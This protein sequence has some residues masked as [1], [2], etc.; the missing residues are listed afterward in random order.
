MARS[1]ARSSSAPA[2][3]VIMP[4]SN[5]ATTSRPSTGSNP[6]KSGIHSVGIGALRDSAKNGC[7]TTVF[8][9][10]PPRC[11]QFGEKSALSPAWERLREL[12]GTEPRSQ[13]VPAMWKFK[14]I[15]AM[16]IESAE[17]ISAEEA[18]RRVL[19][20]ENPGLPGKSR[21]TQTLLAGL[22]L[23]MPGEIAAG[24]R[25]TASAIRFILDGEGAYTTV[26]GE[27]TC[28]SP[29]DFVLTPNWAPHDHGNTTDRPMIWLD[30][31]DVPMINYF[32]TMF[33]ENLDGQT[34]PVTRQDG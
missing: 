18:E 31:L 28:M 19:L 22:Q 16:V 2:S 14:D 33:C 10:S 1:V 26:E 12:I 6:N 21:I 25:H 3:E 15:K 4:A 13:C 9:D 34:Q 17:L 11:T 24:H 8:A 20:L 5:A 23:I 30:V 27:R 29:G 7:G 32:E